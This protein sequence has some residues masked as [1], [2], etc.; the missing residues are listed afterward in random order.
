MVQWIRIHLS[1]QR[2]WFLSLIWEDSTCQW[3]TKLMHHSY[4]A[5][6]LQLLEPEH[7]ESVFCNK[8]RH[9]SENPVHNNKRVELLAAIRKSLPMNSNKDQVLSKNNKISKFKKY[10]LKINKQNFILE[11]PREKPTLGNLRSLFSHILP[12]YGFKLQQN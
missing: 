11:A 12:S 2:I 1:M 3:A 10:I 9:C 7:L 6:M 4:W 5:C 8:R